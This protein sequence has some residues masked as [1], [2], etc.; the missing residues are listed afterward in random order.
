MDYRN[1]TFLFFSILTFLFLLK[2]ASKS[3]KSKLPPGP[4]SWPIIGNIHLFGDKLHYSV[5]N[6]SK[7]YGPIMS[8]KFGT[9][10]TIVI[11][12]P[13]IAKD[14][15]LKH[16]LALSSRKQS[17]AV[18]VLNHDKNSMAWLPVCPKWRNLRK[19]VTIQIFTNHR[20]DASQFIRQ[21]KVSELLEHARWCSENDL[22]VDIGKAGFTASL[23]LLSNT[24]FSVDLASHESSFSQ[25]FKDLVWHIME[26]SGTP[27]IS[28]FFPVVRYLD[29]QGLRKRIKGLF[30]KVMET[31][32]QIINQRMKDEAVSKDDVLDTL[33]KLVEDDTLS[34]DDV[35]HMLLDLFAAGTDTTSSTL[36][37]AFT[38]LL[39]NPEKLANAQNEID[40]VIG[41]HNGPIQ[42]SDI[43]KLPY[44]QAVVKEALRLH[45]PIPFL[46]PHKAEKDVELSGYFVPKNAQI[47]VNVWAIGRDPS[48]WPN[49]LSFSPERFLGSEVDFKGRDFELIPFGAGRRMCPGMPLAHRMVH[50][51]LATLLH[52]F[53]WKHAHGLRPEDIDA[54][55]KFGLTQQ[56]AQ[57]LQA[58]PLMRR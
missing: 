54:E 35:Y 21:K 32:E 52:S 4:K 10:T 9:V 49:A 50:L 48:V 40:R 53:D 19:I 11:S 43:S 47:W 22:P 39:R 56:K 20:L 18:R 8:L 7:A 29:L 24:L 5:T 1:I 57:P 58:I 17:D 27:N 44:I 37:W 12:S 30:L 3:G 28:D 41:K 46:L 31:F 33:L 23:N 42:E 34:L 6:L 38:E 15:F 26:A 2:L 14:M 55:E 51:M 16:D 25:D 13:E 45:P 36:E